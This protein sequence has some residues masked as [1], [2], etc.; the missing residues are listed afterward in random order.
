MAHAPIP[1]LRIALAA[2]W[3]AA[4][5]CGAADLRLVSVTTGGAPGT[6]HS[7]TVAGIYP[8]RSPVTDAGVVAF[9]SNAALS[10]ADANGATYVDLY[11]NDGAT[12]SVVDLPQVYEQGCFLADASQSGTTFFVFRLSFLGFFDPYRIVGATR[13]D[14][15]AVDGVSAAALSGDG[16]TGVFAC[17][18]DPFSRI[19]LRDF[20]TGALSGLTDAANASSADPALSAD[21]SRIVFS[22]DAWNLVE[23]DSNGTKD[24]FLYDRAAASYRLISRPV[25]DVSEQESLSPDISGDGASIAFVSACSLFVAGDTNQHADVFVWQDREFEPFERCSVA[26]DGTEAN[27]DSMT[28]R[29]SASGRFVVFTSAA[30]NL[31]SGVDNGL[32]QVYL[33]DRDAKQIAVLSVDAQGAEADADCY[34]PAISPSGRY[35]TFVSSAI[36]LVSGPNGDYRQVF[37]VDRGVSYANHPPTAA[38]VAV[39]CQ[40]N[41]ETSTHTCD[42][43]LSGSDPETPAE[44]LTYVLDTLPASG[45]LTDATHPDTPITT[46]GHE[47]A[48]ADLPLVFKP[49]ANFEGPLSLVYRASDGVAFSRS[50][51]VA[52]TVADFAF[53]QLRFA[54]LS[55]GENQG[56]DHSPALPID[57]IGMS[58]DGRWVAF[59]SAATNL[60]AGSQI[61]VLLRDVDQGRTWLLAAASVSTH[62][63]AV[64]LDGNAVTY[65]IS[66]NVFWQALGEDGPAGLPITLPLGSGGNASNLGISA[67]GTRVVF[68]TGKSLVAEDVDSSAPDVYVWTPGGAPVLVSQG[69]GGEQTSADCTSPALSADGRFVAFCTKGTLNGEVASTASSIWLKSLESGA[70]SRPLGAAETSMSRPSLSWTGRYLCGV[71]GDVT[72]YDLR[73]SGR[74]V[75]VATIAGS[76][77]PCLSV[78]GRFV[79]LTSARTDF[80]LEDGSMASPPGGVAQAFRYDLHTGTVRPLSV[81]GK[82]ADDY[83]DAASYFGLLSQTG[84]LAAFVSDATNLLNDSN[85]RRDVFRMDLGDVTNTLP[86]ATA[87]TPPTAEDTPLVVQFQG[88]D[89]E[90]NDLRFAIVSQPAH[91]TLG[92]LHMPD[93]GETAPHVTYTPHANWYGTDSFTYRCGDASGWSQQSATVAITV[94]EVNDVP[95][96]SGMPT[97][98]VIAEGAEL[99]FDLR[100]F[101]TDPDTDNALPE[102]DTL[103]FTIVGSSPPAAWATIE[104]GHELVVTPGYGVASK[105]TPAPE[106][107]I[108]LQVTDGRSAAVPAST[109][110]DVTVLDV[111]RAPVVSAV[112]VAP[113]TPYTD[114][115]LTA[116]V[117]VSDPDGDTVTL[118]YRW[119]RNGVVQPGLTAGTVPADATI[120]GESWYAETKATAAGAH[121]AWTAAAPVVIRNSAPVVD[122]IAGVVTDEDNAVLI[123]VHVTDVDAGETFSLSLEQPAHGVV[124]L[125]TGRGGSTG[126]FQVRYTPVQDYF[127]PP[128]APDSFT[129]RASDGQDPSVAVAVAVTVNAV[130]DPPTLTI[131]GDL[132]LAP[133][134]QTGEI[135]VNTDGSELLDVA[136]VDNTP[137]SD[138][139]L[140]LV[141]APTKGYLT[142]AGRGTVLQGAVLT[143]AQ[144][145]LTY[146]ADGGATR[147][148][149]VQFE[150]ADPDDAGETGTLLILIAVQTMT[151]TLHQGWNLI[152]LPLAPDLTDPSGLLQDPQ[153]GL[154]CFLEPVWHWDAAAQRFVLTSAMAEKVGY[155]VY[156]PSDPSGP[157]NLDGFDSDTPDQPLVAG[158]NLVGPTGAGAPC[159][160]PRQDDGTPFPY[161]WIWHWKGKAYVPPPG[162]VFNAGAAYWV[163]STRVQTIRAELGE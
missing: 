12:V 1:F 74:T 32:A 88:T 148:D 160:L 35:V 129:V 19:Y 24:V 99:R 4:A 119:Y 153:T 22:S 43:S 86:T 52:I 123:G 8:R 161:G 63:P 55:D 142:D 145:P 155:W 92:T 53:G 13:T 109:A 59:A 105:A 27:A 89:T 80:T 44:S 3:L 58:G 158:W 96:W 110:L 163:R 36:N 65:T 149:T 72:V 26:S 62:S 37:R 20:Q 46:A 77:Y 75:T 45:S 16:L 121:S 100:P 11:R 34:M 17:F 94:P 30:T 14:Y 150:V 113:A 135:G 18:D 151:L 93:L 127:S 67:D 25:S 112:S 95:V 114:D 156:C 115:V 132:R 50:A 124:A 54:S 116:Q 133:G 98:Q 47:I 97:A 5:W 21:G 141:T 73:A 6:G 90:D 143:F 70:V 48:A 57:R 56:D 79:Y 81:D 103:T 136:D 140:T 118:S 144:F 134:E 85:G 108:S 42:V 91:G 49:A 126:D 102:R 154:P 117:T 9:L 137:E 162:D 15:S 138:V 40:K 128:V 104:N 78:D 33:Y 61:G 7:G 152:S 60:T 64:S 101:V 51:N 87:L 159:A 120:K 146:H 2:A 10:G 130:N 107:E 23:G 125:V 84:R 66:T 106:F 39:S 38:N 68:Q 31:V 69:A 76:S 41:D 82:T 29:L 139:T 83:A 28:P 131:T 122:P 157:L 71:S 111:D 147:D